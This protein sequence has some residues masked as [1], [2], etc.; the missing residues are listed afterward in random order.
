[1]PRQRSEVAA[2]SS[3]EDDD[4]EDTTDARDRIYAVLGHPA[5]WVGDMRDALVKADYTISVEELCGRSMVG[6]V[7]RKQDLSLPSLVQHGSKNPYTSGPS[8]VPILNIEA[9]VIDFPFFSA[10]TDLNFEASVANMQLECRGV[11]IVTVK[12][13]VQHSRTP[14]DLNT[15]KAALS[16]IDSIDALMRL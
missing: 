6:A 3:A 13:P 10:G 16:F 1:V 14:Q 5:L 4:V 7:E 8:W 12:C 11:T 15:G 9:N 2:W